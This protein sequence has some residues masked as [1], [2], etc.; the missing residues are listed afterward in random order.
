[1]ITASTLLLQVNHR[2]TVRLTTANSDAVRFLFSNKLGLFISWMS[3][4][5]S[6]STVD[7]ETFTRQVFGKQNEASQLNCIF[8]LPVKLTPTIKL[9]SRKYTFLSVVDIEPNIFIVLQE[10]QV[11]R[12]SH[13]YLIRQFRLLNTLEIDLDLSNLP[14]HQPKD[15]FETF[16]QCSSKLSIRNQNNALANSKNKLKVDS[17]KEN[18]KIFQKTKTLFVNL[19]EVAPDDMA[20]VFTD[21]DD[22]HRL[23]ENIDKNN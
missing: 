9:C 16:F 6:S 3:H 11:I 18:P 2:M 23:Q 19:T 13:E 20:E 14:E 1:M 21:I 10:N 5:S 15:L 17:S 12:L 4:P 8:M 7:L 22:L